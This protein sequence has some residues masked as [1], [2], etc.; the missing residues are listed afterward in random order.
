MSY[1]KTRISSNNNDFT[2]S[3]KKIECHR[4]I[5]TLQCLKKLEYHRIITTLQCLTKN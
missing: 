5:M 4:I 3:Y 1:K 2:M